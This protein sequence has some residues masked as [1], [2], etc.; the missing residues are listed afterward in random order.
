MRRRVPKKNS[1][2]SLYAC[3]AFFVFMAARII[4]PHDDF[5]ADKTPLV[6]LASAIAAAIAVGGVYLRELRRKR[7]Q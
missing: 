3:T 2:Y 4:L 5:F 1:N 6:Y 7:A